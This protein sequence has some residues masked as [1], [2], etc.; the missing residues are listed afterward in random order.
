VADVYDALTTKRPYKKALSHE[1]S[2]EIIVSGIG[3]QFDPKIVEAFLDRE[4]EFQAIAE[5]QSENQIPAIMA[6]ESLP[7]TDVPVNS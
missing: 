1:A 3:T 5:N 2:K 7:L 6:L 4:A